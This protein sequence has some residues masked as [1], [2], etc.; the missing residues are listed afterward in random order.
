MME[1]VLDCPVF[2]IDVKEPRWTG[3]FWGEACD[4]IESL[5]RRLACS[6]IGDSPPD[7]EDLPDVG[8][9]EI[10]V[11]L[12]TGPDLTGFE[13]AVFLTDRCRLRGEKPPCGERQYPPGGPVDCL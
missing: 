6:A 1:A 8:E 3:L 12:G 11:Q 9:L 7:L 13:A 10:V 4:A 5:D 2:A